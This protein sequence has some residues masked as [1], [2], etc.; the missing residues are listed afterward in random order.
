M[1]KTITTFTR[2]STSVAFFT[3]ADNAAVVA[4]YKSAGKI[5]DTKIEDSANGLTRTFTHTFSTVEAQ[6][7]FKN[8]ASRAP[9]IEARRAY[10]SAHGIT[11]TTTTA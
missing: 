3:S 7:E 1:A 5:V 10:N 11:M 6:N 9:I 2:P 4:A 8:D